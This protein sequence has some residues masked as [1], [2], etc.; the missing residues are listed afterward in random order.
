MMLKIEHYVLQWCLIRLQSIIKQ[1]LRII[2]FFFCRSEC[3]IPDFLSPKRQKPLG[4]VYTW[5]KSVFFSKPPFQF[6][7]R[8]YCFCRFWWLHKRF[9][10]F[11]FVKVK[12]RKVKY[13]ISSQF[14]KNLRPIFREVELLKLNFK[15]C[16]DWFESCHEEYS[17][18]IMKQIEF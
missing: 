17:F 3:F 9:Y 18:R 4:S 1:N 10:V 5:P 16:S 13:F 14:F 11:F 8:R 15:Y 6:R 12:F 7:K 2:P